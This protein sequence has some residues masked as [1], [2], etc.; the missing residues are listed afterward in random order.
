MKNTRLWWRMVLHDLTV[1]QKL[2]FRREQEEPGTRHERWYIMAYCC[3]SSVVGT[4]DHHHFAEVLRREA[5]HPSYEHYLFD[6]IH[7]PSF[8]RDCV[9][10]S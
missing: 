3:K 5:V 2:M 4:L 8:V 7:R 1:I 9:V 6:R 10:T